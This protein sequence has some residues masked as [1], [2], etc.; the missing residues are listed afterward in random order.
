MGL[1]FHLKY[2]ISYGTTTSFARLDNIEPP[3]TPRCI[4]RIHVYSQMWRYFDVGL[5]RFLFKWVTNNNLQINNIQ[6]Y[7]P[8]VRPRSSIAANW[9][10]N[11][12]RSYT[13]LVQISKAQCCRSVTRRRYGV[14]RH[15][16]LL[17]SQWVW[18]TPA[19][20]L[21]FPSIRVVILT[22][23]YKAVKARLV[24]LSLLTAL[25]NSPLII[26]YIVNKL[27]FLFRYIYTPVYNTMK[28]YVT[29]NK[30]IYKLL[31]SLVTFMF[32]FTWHGTTWSIFVWSVLNYFGIVLEYSGKAI[33]KTKKYIQFKQSFLKT[34]AMETRFIAFLCT[35]LLG[36]SAISNF[37]LF[38][39]TDVGNLYFGLF[40]SPSLINCILAY[41][42][43]YSCCHVAIALKN[44]PS[45]TDLEDSKT[46]LHKHTTEN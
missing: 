10:T 13:D 4:A 3:P 16:A 21:C 42:A 31:S 29:M 35:P 7:W 18:W 8:W 9:E 28:Y 23:P 44:V 14:G 24:D 20:C 26:L 22:S 11:I 40:K 43:L 45:R 36:L 25:T 39:G 2:V 46:V 5:Y 38:A 32:I 41:L 33:G 17:H 6:K 34:D 37:Y 15:A 27:Y 1:E 12:C 19:V 30:M